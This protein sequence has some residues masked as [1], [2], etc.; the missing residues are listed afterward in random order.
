MGVVGCEV[1][2]CYFVV[3][4][5]CMCVC[6]VVVMVVYVWCFYFVCVFGV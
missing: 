1:F 5:V 2:G 3:M 4:F 6:M